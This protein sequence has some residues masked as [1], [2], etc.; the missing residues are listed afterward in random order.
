VAARLDEMALNQPE[1][2][3]VTSPGYVS[4]SPEEDSNGY[5]YSGRSGA[6]GGVQGPGNVQTTT[7]PGNVQ[8]TGATSTTLTTT[9]TTSQGQGRMQGGTQG[10]TQGGRG[11]VGTTHTQNTAYVRGPNGG[12][13]PNAARQQRNLQTIG[14]NFANSLNPNKSLQQSSLQ[15]NTHQNS[16][17]GAAQQNSTQ[18]PFNKRPFNR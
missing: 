5:V 13:P 2:S 12:S 8:T 15:Q 14:N 18:K 1:D 16:S 4:A 6:S 11:G 3:S 10:G 17:R 7:G 9:T